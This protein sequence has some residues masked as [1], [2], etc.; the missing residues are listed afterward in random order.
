MYPQHN[1]YTHF[2][3]ETGLALALLLSML[4]GIFLFPWWMRYTCSALS[5]SSVTFYNKLTKNQISIVLALLTCRRT[6]LVHSF[7]QLCVAAALPP[8]HIWIGYTLALTYTYMFAINF[9]PISPL[10][11]HTCVAYVCATQFIIKTAHG[12]RE[13]AQA[14]ARARAT[15]NCVRC[16]LPWW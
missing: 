16:A 15:L 14:R 3:E 4:V 7:S 12:M 11:A 1:I 2:T 9:C 8:V 5:V 10:V 6:F 13:Q